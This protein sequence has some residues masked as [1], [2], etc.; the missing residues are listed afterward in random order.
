MVEMDPMYYQFTADLLAHLHVI[1]VGNKLKI[2]G[3]FIDNLLTTFILSFFV[4]IL[5]PKAYLS[6]WVG[7]TTGIAAVTSNFSTLNSKVLQTA[8][9]KSLTRTGFRIQVCD[10]QFHRGFALKKVL[11]VTQIMMHPII[12]RL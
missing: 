8:A 2:N 7:S 11:P 9:V 5:S 10:L 1:F 4:S 6:S 3:A 12:R